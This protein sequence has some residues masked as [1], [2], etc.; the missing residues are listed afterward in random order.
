MLKNILLLTIT[1]FSFILLSPEILDLD[2]VWAQTH[3]ATIPVGDTP[4]DL[5]YN[6]SNE[7]IYVVNLRSHFVSVIDSST[8]TVIATVDVGDFSICCGI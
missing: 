2:K 3:I 7:N 1:I 8:N 6:P 4:V 5:E